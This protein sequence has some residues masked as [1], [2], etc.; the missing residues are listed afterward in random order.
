MNYKH[1]SLAICLLAA[2]TATANTDSSKPAAPAAAE[3]KVPNIPPELAM[4]PAVVPV[5]APAPAPV[6]G[7]ALIAPVAPP[8]NSK[9][10][11]QPLQVPALSDDGCSANACQST[12][13]KPS[14]KA[15]KRKLELA[16]SP[17]VSIGEPA[18]RAVIESHNWA[19]NR[20]AMPV[21]DAGG[22]VVFPF[23][24]SAP[25]IVCAP[26][27]VCDIELQAG[28][29]VQGAP[30]IGDGI[31]WKVAP[32]VS[33]SDDQKV[34]HLII[35]PTE[36]G[37]DT[38]LI[39][40]TDRRTYHIRLVSSAE[41]YVSRIAFEY[42][43][44]DQPQAW[45]AL[46]KSNGSSTASKNSKG[47]MPA[48]AVNRL[49]FNYKIKV[50]KGHPYFKP[51]RAMDDGYH[52]YIAMNEELPQQQAPALIGISPSGEE[53]MINYRLKGNMYVVDGTIFKLAL[54]SGV[55]SDQQR[56]EVARDECQKR[57]WLGICW[58]AKE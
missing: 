30:H 42:P 50:V 9:A 2:G 40:T 33:G 23:G 49:N 58:D 25:T 7:A 47:D 8:A 51:L 36:P 21:R 18:Q 38:N 32:A 11:S 48:V 26:L 44:E 27:R 15:R 37:L 31:R 28:E 41:R 20:L 5:L 55:G 53:Q 56:I 35:K 3:I 16:L 52:T 10:D 34:T 13:N 17:S 24:E 1:L 45:E 39:I 54:I 22:R 43:D 57:G 29:T 12:P 6:P 19:E 14:A 46:A 4:P